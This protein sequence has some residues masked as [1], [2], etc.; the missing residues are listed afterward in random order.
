MDKHSENIRIIRKELGMTQE[1]ISEAMGIQRSTYGRFER[2]ETHMLTAN[3]R[4]FLRA[5]GKGIEDIIYPD[6]ATRTGLLR[7]ATL[8][9]RVSEL[10]EEVRNLR[11]IIEMLAARLEKQSKKS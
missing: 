3:T 2:G 11:A 8:D 6:G 9:D 4:K 10:T 5:T 7:Q 1:E